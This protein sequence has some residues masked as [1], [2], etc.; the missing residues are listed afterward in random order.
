MEL[1]ASTTVLVPAVLEHPDVESVTTAEEAFVE[2]RE[3]AGPIARAE[4]R[5]GKSGRETRIS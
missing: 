2:A 3:C 1:A 4:K 5:I